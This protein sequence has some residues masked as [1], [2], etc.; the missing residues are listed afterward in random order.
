MLD[1][2]VTPPGIF[3]QAREKAMTDATD[4]EQPLDPQRPIIDPHLHLWEN[5]VVPGVMQVP[6]RFLLPEV[7]E[8]IARC[9]H[10]I[11]HTVFVE[12]HAMYRLEG[13]PELAPVGE[14]EFVNGIA[15]MSASGGYG[16]CRVAHRIVGSADPCL[17]AGIVPVLEAHR[18]SAGDRFR[19]VRFTTAFSE[20]GMF[21]ASCDPRVRGVMLHPQFR[22]AARALAKMDLSLDVWCLHSQLDEVIDLA[23]AIPD[24]TIILDHIGT[25]ES[26]G[27]YAGREAETRA[28]WAGKIGELSRR[29]NVLVKLGGM[30]M[31]LARPIGGTSGSEPSSILAA[32]W[33]PY[34]ETCIEAFS[35]QRC[36][37]E[38]NFPPDNAA[39][40]YGA[41]W[42]AFKTIVGNFSKDEQDWLFRHTAADTYRISL[43]LN[44]ERETNSEGSKRSACTGEE[45]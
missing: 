1:G 2:V 32:S 4:E 39:G 3:N 19:G 41:T 33:R 34:I 16:P 35:P 13:P 43:D 8:T 44:R 24:L 12:C 20:A 5:P 36:M 29:P 25:P 15:A 23:A 6:Q 11:T 28:Q 17:G 14:T 10:N 18:A 38:S 42:N 7:L 9:G 40:T 30:G 26:L 21:G 37:F 22:E 45:N 31:D 27:A